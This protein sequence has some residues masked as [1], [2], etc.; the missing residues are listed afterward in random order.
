MFNSYSRKFWGAG[1]VMSAIM[2]GV[3]ACSL[4]KPSTGDIIST[5]ELARHDFPYPS[6]YAKV[7]GSKMHFVDTG[8]DKDPILMLHGQ[9]TWSY[10]WRD[11]IP[12]LEKDHRVIALDLI[13]FGKSDKPDISYTVEDHAKYLNEFIQT[14]ELNNITLV[15]HDWG[16]FL[17]F[18][19]AAQHPDKIKAIAFMESVVPSD[20]KDYPDSPNKPIMDN[21]F[22]IL[23]EIKTPGVGEKMILED[24]FFIEELLLSVPGLSEDEKNAYREP[25]AN[26]KN[27]LPMLQFPRQ[28]SFDGVEPKYVVAGNQLIES[29][30]KTTPVPKL[31][32]T[33]TPGAIVGDSNIQWAKNHMSNLQLT[34]IGEG[35]HFVQETHPKAIGQTINQWMEANDLD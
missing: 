1:L 5:R 22:Q 32:L 12:E 33:F 11:V 30:L 13:G 24:N 27:R 17:G 28:I 7:L 35:V 2:A 29:Y 20:G 6:N 31:M 16:S 3:S 34:H 23:T 9:P 4:H 21:F 25:F 18:D 8:G 26:G 14:L 19:F 10:L 15:I